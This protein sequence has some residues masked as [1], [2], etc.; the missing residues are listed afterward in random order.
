MGNSEKERSVPVYSSLEEAIH[1]LFGNSRSVDTKIP[2]SGGDI[3]EAYSLL[4]DDGTTVFMKENRAAALQAFRA[5]AAGLSAIEQTGAVRTP[6]VL[7]AGTDGTRSFLLL[8]SIRE[9]RRIPRYWE[10]FAQ[11]LAAMHRAVPAED[12]YGFTEDNFIGSSPQKNTPHKSWAEFFRECRLKPQFQ[13]AHMWFDQEDQRRISGFLE[14]LE[15][16]LE[17]P[18][19]PSLVHGDLWAGNYMTGPDGK[20]WL[21]DPAAY[22]GHPEADLA[23]TQLFGGFPPS[24]YEAYR[25]ASGLDA[26][27]YSGRR[28][29]Y[30]LYHLLNHLNL[31]GGGYLGAVRRVINRYA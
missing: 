18:E 13:M 3:N 20:A 2:V 6:R 22:Y 8:E 27:G 19:R 7:S 31:F 23:M 14:K 17:E 28:D 15:D 25:E 12:T 30:N 1:G 4:L 10:T 24:F 5:E 11:E 29:L 9:G 26:E 21:I 16:Y